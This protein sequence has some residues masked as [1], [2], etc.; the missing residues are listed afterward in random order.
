M[1]RPILDF[2][3]KEGLLNRDTED[4]G[5]IALSDTVILRKAFCTSYTCQPAKDGKKRIDVVVKVEKKVKPS[6][7]VCPDCGHVLF[8]EAARK[9][10]KVYVHDYEID[11]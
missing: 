7:A 3:H 9:P 5:N 2:L 8:W 11:D 6:A 1:A 10:R 4:L